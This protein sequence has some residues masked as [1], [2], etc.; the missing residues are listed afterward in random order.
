MK[1]GIPETNALAGE[2]EIKGQLAVAARASTGFKKYN[3]QEEFGE[4][5]TFLGLRKIM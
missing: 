2:M 1:Y 4:F 3:V 5:W